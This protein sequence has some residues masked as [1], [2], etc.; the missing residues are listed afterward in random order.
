M[1]V[2]IANACPTL[3]AMTI[4]QTK[5]RTPK[6]TRPL[7]TPKP[8]ATSRTLALVEVSQYPKL[9]RQ[10]NLPTRVAGSATKK[11]PKKRT[12]RHQRASSKLHKA[13]LDDCLS[14]KSTMRVPIPM[15]TQS[16]RYC[17]LS[18]H[19]FSYRVYTSRI[20]F[21]HSSRGIDRER[22]RERER[23]RADRR[24]GGEIG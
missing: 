12:P 4:L 1:L 6:K 14:Y 18:R 13:A 7:L 8:L 15:R 5:T 11:A 21:I 24:P 17:G 9:P 19:H 22:E 20:S 16:P 10:T 2:A 23:E 3:P